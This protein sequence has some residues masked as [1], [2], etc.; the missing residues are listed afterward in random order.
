[1]TGEPG[2]SEPTATHRDVLAYAVA[3]IGGQE[4]PG[5]VEMADAIASAFESGRHLLV[6][7]GTGTGKSLGYLAPALVRLAQHPGERIVVATA[8]LALQSQLANAD[9]PAALDAVEAVLGERPRHA[10]LKGRTNYACLLKVRDSTAAEQGALISAGDLAETIKAAPLSSPESALGAEV[11]ALR[12]WAEEQAE[13]GGLADRDDAP[14]HTE[15]AWQQVSIPVR[16]CLTPQRCPYGDACF[17]EQSRDEARAADLVVTNHAL[18]AIDAMHGGTALPEHQAVIIDEAHELVARVTGAASAELTPGLVERVA[19]RA[20][21]YLEDEDAL[22]LLESADALRGGLEAVPLER[23]T[24]PDSPFVTACSEVRNAARA[25]VSALSSGE[26]KGDPDRR[27]VAAAVREVFD[28]AERMA[29]L[30]E[31]DVVWVAERERFGREARVAPLSVAGLDAGRGL[32]RADHGADLGHVEARRGL[33]R[34]RRQH[35][36][37]RG[38]AARRVRLA[39]RTGRGGGSGA[40]CGRARAV[41]RTGRRL[42][43]RIPAAGDPLCRPQPASA[44]ARGHVGG[45]SGRDSRV[46]LGRGRTDLGVVQLPPGG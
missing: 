41:A 23:V 34:D 36:A 18:L 13:A 2:E 27:Q 11:L 6:Q 5:Q 45:G 3:S 20:L 37:A 30:A 42:A 17:V 38:R 10:I 28:I 4:R 32:R 8:T 43:V 46:G 12:E 7:A 31:A 22:A 24:D 15:R 14:S 25:A 39:A 33:R 16:E 9:I 1:M 35:R 21:T 44:G 26:E 40:R 29:A 19:R